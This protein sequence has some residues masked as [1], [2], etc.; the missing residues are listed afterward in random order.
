MVTMLH[1]DQIREIE[2]RDLV[3]LYAKREIALVRGQGVTLWDSDGKEYLDCMSNYGVN[4][5]GHAHPAVSAAIKEQVDILTNCHSS[6]YN[7]ARARFLAIL[8]EMAPAELTRAFLSSSGA[9][10][11]E[12]ALKFARVATGRTK[13]VATKRAYHGRTL[14]ALAATAEKKYRDP[15]LPLMEG[16]SHVAY[17]DVDALGAAVDEG[18][19]AV[20]LEPI[21]GEGGIYVPHDDYL[22]AAHEIAR[23]AGAL[24][25]FD[26]VQTAFRTGTLFACQDAGV[27][28][29]VLCVSKGIANGFPLALTLVTEEVGGRIPAG[30]HGTTFGGNPLACAAGAATLTALRDEDRFAQ[31]A[32]VGA[33]F[34]DQLRGLN[35]PKVREVRGR[36]LMIG[37]E[38]KE[39]ATKYLRGLQEGGVLALMAG[40]TTLRFLP[41]LLLTEADVDRAVAVFGGLLAGGAASGRDGAEA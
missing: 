31:S 34:R 13:V 2:D 20:I 37:V 10:S 5:L 11:I 22:A 26:E 6:F 19:A 8:S 1:S 28:P 35:S 16:F 4:V 38:L 14:G 39:R 18:T 21:Q 32:R 27:I 29:D 41:P 7:D 25:I 40:A 15:F 30:S 23:R 33:Y 36:G 12:A 24:L 3:G 9:E 17:N